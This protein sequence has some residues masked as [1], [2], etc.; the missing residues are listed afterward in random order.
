MKVIFSIVLI[1]STISC[2]AV[3]EYQTI[4]RQEL[5]AR[6]ERLFGPDKPKLSLTTYRNLDLLT[7]FY[8]LCLTKNPPTKLLSSW[9]YFWFRQ[10]LISEL[11][12]YESMLKS[13]HNSEIMR[14]QSEIQSL[15]WQLKQSKDN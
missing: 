3:R 9:D 13:I 2:A 6:D 12:I 11:M 4:Y 14:L 10:D 8:I 7:A 1:L 15:I 5:A